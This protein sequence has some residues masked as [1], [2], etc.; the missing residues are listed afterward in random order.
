M[1]WAVVNV[2][3]GYG[4]VDGGAPS[5]LPYDA[6][7]RTGITFWA[8]IGDT[9]TDQVRLNVTDRYS[10]DAGGIC[11]PAATGDPSRYCY[12]HF[13]TP[14]TKLTTEWHRY[15]IPFLGLGQLGFGI[16]RP[17]VDTTAIYSIDFLFPNAPFDLWIDDV[18]FY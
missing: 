3:M 1:E 9:S 11:D 7:F 18:Y 15:K 6:S 10:N 8:R 17:H 5:I 12:D 4:S 2:S 14:L 13:G 16:P